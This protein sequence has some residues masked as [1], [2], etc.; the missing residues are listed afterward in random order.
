MGTTEANKIFASENVKK[1]IGFASRNF[2]AT[3][4]AALHVESHSNL[5]FGEPF[6][7]AKP[8][9]MDYIYLAKDTKYDE[10]MQKYKL[11]H[12]EFKALNIHVESK[13]LKKG[14]VI[15]KGTLL[16]VPQLATKTATIDN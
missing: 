9:N 13:F 1:H 6:M 4:L 14:R 11:E 3:F 15:P 7:V 12:K 8:L 5:Y 2:Y 16:S 10:L